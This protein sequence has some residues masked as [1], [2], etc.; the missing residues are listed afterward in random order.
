MI[1]FQVKTVKDNLTLERVAIPKSK[2]LTP[3]GDSSSDLS[4]GKCGSAFI[5]TRFKHWLRDTIGVD[6]YAKLD[7]ANGRQRIGPHTPESGHIR[8]LMKRFEVKK[9]NF[10]NANQD[11][12]RLD[13]PGPLSN[14]SL[15]GRVN[16]GE[17]TIL[18]SESAG[19]TI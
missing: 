15:E 14:F 13:L 2:S 8:E 6:N 19:N 1:S 18:W 16:Q 12:I 11:Y 5:D 3:D 10:S 7:P 17:L 9:R 4:G